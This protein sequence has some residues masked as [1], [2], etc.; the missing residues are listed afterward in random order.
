[1]PLSVQGI[2][3]MYK[4]YKVLMEIEGDT[5]KGEP[6]SSMEPLCSLPFCQGLTMEVVALQPE[7]SV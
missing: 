1:M 7:P 3:V 4:D 5:A 6:R 2:A